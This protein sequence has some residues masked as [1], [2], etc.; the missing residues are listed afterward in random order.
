MIA[1]PIAGGLI[2]ILLIIMA[3]RMLR[4]DY[5]RRSENH[6]GL[7]KAQHFIE[8]HFTRKDNK[9]KPKGAHS[10]QQASLTSES[11]TEKLL[12]SV[13]V[14]HN[15]TSTRHWTETENY[16]KDAK[17]Q[18]SPAQVHLIQTSKAN[19]QPGSIV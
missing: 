19:T 18:L 2:L 5:H 17:P 7:E 3:I 9:P 11:S 15:T 8:Q 16:M 14:S 6:G 10:K 1:V 12:N 4:E 13:S